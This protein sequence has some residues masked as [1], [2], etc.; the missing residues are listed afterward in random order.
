MGLGSKAI[1]GCPK[2][3]LRLE[4]RLVGPWREQ[5]CSQWVEGSQVCPLTSTL[6]SSWPFMGSLG[7]Q[8]AVCKAPG[9]RTTLRVKYMGHGTQMFGQTPVWIINIENNRQ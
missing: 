7:L 3:E 9:H 4:Q 6:A 2:C 8:G 1:W 5:N